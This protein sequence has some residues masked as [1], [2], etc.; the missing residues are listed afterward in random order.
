[1][2]AVFKD[3]EI[4]GIFRRLRYFVEIQGKY[5]DETNSISLN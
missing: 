3:N 4:V 2:L 1:M 5:T